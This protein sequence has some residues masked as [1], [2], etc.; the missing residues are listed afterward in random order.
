MHAH[1]YLLFESGMKIVL[2]TIALCRKDIR[3]TVTRT[4]RTTVK[5]IILKT[6]IDIR[7]RLWSVNYWY[8]IAYGG[9]INGISFGN[10]F[11]A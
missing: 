7:S 10:L 6:I 9:P 8:I 5:L 3:S 1:H 11:C 2:C 4:Q